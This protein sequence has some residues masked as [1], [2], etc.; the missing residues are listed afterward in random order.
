MKLIKLSV[1]F[2]TVY[3]LYISE[4]FGAIP[5]FLVLMYI[6]LDVALLSNMFR[7]RFVL[8]GECKSVILFIVWAAV[9]GMSLA[10]NQEAFLRDIVLAI[11]SV[12]LFMSLYYIAIYE[13]TPMFSA[14]TFYFM[15][16]IYIITALINNNQI[17]GRLAISATANA[18]TLGNMCFI[19]AG[20]SLLIFKKIKY[21]SILMISSVCIS[22]Y[23]AILSG[24]KKAFFII[25][26]FNLLMLMF[27][28]KYFIMKKTRKSIVVIVLTF[29]LLGCFGTSISDF[30]ENSIV[31]QRILL[32]DKTDEV[33][34]DL[35]NEAISTFL[36]NPIM[37]VGFQQSTYY[38]S[39]SLYTHSGFMETLV[40]TGLIGFI[41]WIQ[42]YVYAL[43]HSLSNLFKTK[44]YDVTIWTFVWLV[45]QIV[46]EFTSV[47][48]YY[49]ANFAMLGCIAAIN[50]LHSKK[51]ESKNG[52]TI[53]FGRR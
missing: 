51:G 52:D 5:S 30:F 8:T 4:V 2:A 43:K 13:K 18:N 9:S 38:S 40:G 23:V 14:K 26:V 50:I 35:Y 44:D 17:S 48:Y 28:L 29:V 45:C 19:C 10:I 34:L 11:E 15:A 41:I 3:S 1:F 25:L 47:S 46:L 32:A 36:E 12:F 37:G 16:L 42:Y 22:L 33:R 27:K 53:F 20:L 39:L 49:P 7:H 6:L 24:S 31:Y 21:G